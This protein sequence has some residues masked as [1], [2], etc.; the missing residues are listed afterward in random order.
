M[1]SGR[2]TRCL[3]SSLFN[4]AFRPGV[5]PLLCDAGAFAFGGSG[6]LQA[7]KRK[8]EVEL[9]DHQR[10]AVE[11][12]LERRRVLIGDEMGVGKTPTAV[13]IAATEARA[14]RTPVLIVVP[15]S[16]RLQWQREFSRF[17]PDVT[18][19]TLTGRS[20]VAD[21]RR[22]WCYPDVDV[23]IIG[24]L[25]LDGYAKYLIGEMAGII[26]DECQRIK[27]R[28]ALRTAACVRI[29]ASIPD[30]GVRVVM[31]GT[32]LIN[33]PVELVPSL[34]VIDRLDDFA[35]SSTGTS[36]YEYFLN[37][38]APRIN[39]FGTRGVANLDELHQRLST[40]FMIRRKRAEVLTLP[41]KGRITTTVPVT[42][43]F[44]AQYVDAERDLFSFIERSKGTPHAERA[45][46]AEAIVRLNVLRGIL[47]H[48]KV[49]AVFDY[50]RNL[51][52]EG[53]QVFITC[54][55]TVVL[56][57]LVQRFRKHANTV[58]ISG[59]MTDREKMRAVDQFQSGEA[60]VLVGNIV[61][62]GV[63]LTLTSGRH[64]V[65]AEL[66][67]SSADLMQAE[68][69]LARF[70]QNREVVSH[71]LLAAD[72]NSQPTLDWRMFALVDQK[73]DTLSQVLDGK[74]ARLV[75][76]DV[77]SVALAVLR[78]YGWGVQARPK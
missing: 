71:I 48:G 44:V 69:R 59:G 50:A 25:S 53:E 33:H 51:L 31:S 72:I 54:T 21:R 5:A 12:A 43:R 22:S 14:G 39:R 11:Y 28:R 4:H 66:P 40:G 52:H 76:D 45:M 62:A 58:Q 35:D 77:E 30:G 70:G 67:W 17:A 64:H 60:R 9:L 55:H 78:S 56:R 68:D 34:R 13:A 10:V 74:T 63:G 32:P 73:L 19:A 15:P 7:V 65:N 1:C 24:D 20:P 57:S 16:M 26:V 2:E 46:R 18:T 3:S 37:R 27:S 29:A 42:E 38:Y 23:L 61:A 6:S 8:P 75:D 36:G 49:D 47:G 41:N